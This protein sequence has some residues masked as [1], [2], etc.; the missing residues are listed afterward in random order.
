MTPRSG[1]RAILRGLLR[2]AAALRGF[3]LGFTGLAT[4]P[5]L[6]GA[7][8]RRRLDEEAGRRPRCC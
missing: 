2:G 1:G 5:K 6:T 3:L 7:A 4:A 8:D